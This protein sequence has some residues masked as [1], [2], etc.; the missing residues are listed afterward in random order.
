[1]SSDDVDFSFDG[2]VALSYDE[3]RAHPPEVSHSVAAVIA[4]EVGPN[5]RILEPGVGTGRIALPL[6]AAGCKVVGADISAPML[7]ALAEKS[8]TSPGQLD[9]IRCDLAK[10]PLVP[11][12]FDAIVCVHVLHLIAD[13]QNLLHRLV[14][15]LKPG[16]IM[17]LGRDWI[18]PA[19][20]AGQIRNEFRRA[21]VELSETIVSP[22]GARGF[23][24]ALIE[25]GMQAEA[26]GA[27]RTAAEW[28]TQLAPGQVL[29]E[30]RSKND[31]ESWVLPDE[32]LGRVMERLDELAA[33]TWPDTDEPQPVKRRFVYSVLRAP[34]PIEAGQP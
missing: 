29:D 5:A 1:M 2:R 9:L 34:R 27:E 13:W 10:L 11:G 30:I 18:D 21:V 20:F 12:S 19:S 28:Q 24:A 4:A 26:D 22:P 17:I 3:V 15:L 6:V 25:L 16:G 31:A 32:L 7:T 14:A 33:K 8:Q 23:V